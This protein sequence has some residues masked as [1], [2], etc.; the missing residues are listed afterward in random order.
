MFNDRD[1]V[2][3]RPRR[4]RGTVLQVLAGLVAQNRGLGVGRGTASS[5]TMLNRALE[6]AQRRALHDAAVIIISD[7]D[8]ADEATRRSVGAMAQHND[9]VALLVH[10]PI[11]SDLPASARLTVTDGELQIVLEVGRGT[12]RRRIMDAT[13]ERLRGVFAWTTDLGVPVLPLSA[14]EETAPQVRRLLGRLP[15]RQGRGSHPHME[16]ALG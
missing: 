1:L 7:F 4:S 11:Q 10:D 15:A 12:V 8:G 6:Q 13:Q 3:V 2:E 9:V 5:P 16:A 14:A